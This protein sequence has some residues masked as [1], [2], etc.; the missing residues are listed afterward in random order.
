[1]GFL[2]R[3]WR[4]LRS[5]SGYWSFGTLVGGG[6]VA[7]VVLFGDFNAF[8]AYS[9]TES[10]CV[11]CHEMRDFPAKEIQG[12]IHRDNRTG[13]HAACADCHVPR[14]YFEAIGHKIYKSRELFLHMAGRLATPELFEENRMRLASHVWARMKASDSEVCRA[15]HQTVWTNTTKQWGGAARTHQ[16]AA[17]SGDLTCID[18]HQGI[19]HTLPKGFERPKTKELTADGGKWLEE[20]KAQ[21]GE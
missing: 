10:F 9:N 4:F 14:N 2:A 15:C 16:L 12:T 8:V 1:M 5:P 17:Q 20:V 19:A 7:G 18:C 11:G 6:L 21:V 13:F 3:I